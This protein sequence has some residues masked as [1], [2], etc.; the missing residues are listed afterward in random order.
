MSTYQ[1]ISMSNK[2]HLICTD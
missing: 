2:D 1:V